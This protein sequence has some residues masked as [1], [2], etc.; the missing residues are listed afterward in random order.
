MKK[1]SSIIQ[2][3]KQN[4]DL[5]VEIIHGVSITHLSSMWLLLE[6]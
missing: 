6:K 1:Q 5:K 3:V 2:L 4:K